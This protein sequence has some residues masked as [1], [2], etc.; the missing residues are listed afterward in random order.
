DRCK[1][2]REL[3]RGTLAADHR[4]EALGF[5]AGDALYEPGG[6]E[7]CGGTGYRGRNGVFELLE[8]KDEVYDL[9]GPGADGRMIDL[10]ARRAGM[11]TMVED[12]IA[13]CRSGVTS[14]A[15]VLRVTSLR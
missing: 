14:A 12:G 13:K 2:K 8:L 7:R 10:A 15:E 11:M 9:V 1:K 5:K 6:C 3:D 4:Y